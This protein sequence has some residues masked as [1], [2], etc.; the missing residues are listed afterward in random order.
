MY[1]VKKTRSR[2]TFIGLIIKL[3]L[4]IILVIGLFLLLNQIEFPAPNKDIKKIIPNENFKTI[5]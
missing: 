1:F 3:T 4:S 2:G 5:K